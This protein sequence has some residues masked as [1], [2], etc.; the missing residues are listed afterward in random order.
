MMAKKTETS[1]R[2]KKAT[3]EGYGDELLQL[4]RERD[5]I[6]V[7]DADLSGSTKTNKFAG[8]FKNRFFNVGVAEQNMIGMAAGFAISGL[9][10]F[11]SSFAMFLSGR[12]WEVIRNSVGYPGL[13]VK[14]V[15]SHGGITVGEDGASHQCIED[16]S[17]MRTIPG[18]RVFIPADY[19]ETRM[20]IRHIAALDG[21]CY[22]RC[23]RSSLP[24]LEHTNKGPFQEGKGEIRRNGKDI[25]IIACGIMVIE[26]DKAGSILE[27][28]G[29]DAAIINMASIKPID[30][31][32]IINFARKTGAII[33]VE[34]HN[35]IGGL[36]SAVTEIVSETHPVP[37]V[38][39]GLKDEFG[40]S[41]QADT[42]LDHY[43][44]RAE[45]IVRIAL[46][47]LDNQ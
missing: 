4:G 16:L 19:T 47:I 32:L 20:I 34:E 15:A 25:T 6:V 5:D 27:K 41:G 24:L 22:V 7:L 14:M 30:S 10:P 33:T 13:N 31:D 12:A 44:L 29:I 46:N 21:P 45:N 23:G 1:G 38:R 3:R 36:G 37:V 9:I 40:Q 39:I 26:A 28:K 42:L 2:E 11:A 17:L 18:M 43:G 35:I 8:E